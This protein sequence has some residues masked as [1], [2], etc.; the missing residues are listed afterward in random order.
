MREESRWTLTIAQPAGVAVRV[1][2]FFWLFAAWTLY[3][4]WLGER[5]PGDKGNLVG[6]STG[7]LA[8]L[9]LSVLWHELGH[10]WATRVWGGAMGS[11]VIGPFGGLSVLEPPARPRQEMLVL[12]AGPVA[13]G[14]CAGIAALVLYAW[15][16][17]NVG[18]LH[19][20]LPE[21]IVE[22][23]APLV[24]LKL[25]LWVNWLLLLLNLMPGFPF[26]GGRALRAAILWRK[27]HLGRREA[28]LIVTRFARLVACLMIL[29]AVLAWRQDD[30]SGGAWLALAVLAVFVFFGAEQENVRSE[31]RPE[32]TPALPRSIPAVTLDQNHQPAHQDISRAMPTLKESFESPFD[33]GPDLEEHAAEALARARQREDDE[34][35]DEVLTRVFERGINALSVAEREVLNRASERYRRRREQPNA[36]T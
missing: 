11:L 18:M 35:V 9:A 21:M 2:L 34:L 23:S 26:D 1:H 3:I 22:G 6:L 12:L 10:W 20:M 27:P 30:G 15:G 36:S 33:L 17:W 31:A 32:A 25:V 5:S 24:A 16:Q 7:C 8:V 4:A 13:N 28:A 19:P 29:A 14:V